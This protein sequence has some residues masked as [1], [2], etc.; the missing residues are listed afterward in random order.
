MDRE[1]TLAKSSKLELLD[2]VRDNLEHITSTVTGP[3]SKLNKSDTNA[4]GACVREVLA[5]V[6][7]LNLRLS[8]AE[9]ELAEAN[10]RVAKAEN[11]A[12]RSELTAKDKAAPGISY[13]TALKLSRGGEPTPMPS[14][15]GPVIAFYPAQEQSDKIRTAEDTKA[16]LKKAIKPVAMEVQVERLRKVGNAGVIVQT[17]TAEGAEKLK[18]AAP[19]TL[20][21]EVP[22]SRSPQVCLRNLDGDLEST[23]ILAA[24]YEKNF[25]GSSWTVARI[26]A[27]CKVFRRRGFRGTTTAVLECSATF[28]QAILEKG[29]VGHVAE[30]RRRR[31]EDFINGHDLLI[32]NEA[33][34]PFTFCGPNG[35]SNIDLTVSTRSCKVHEWQV[36]V[37]MS[38][39][40][41][42]L[43]TFLVGNDTRTVSGNQPICIAPTRFR[44]S[45][46]CWDRFRAG[47]NS[48]MG[49]L[50]ELEERGRRI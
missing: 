12:L 15:N 2:R 43:L 10:L 44:E 40:D 14:G 30:V 6:A 11:R 21:V 24:L 28:R 20:R 19:S 38:S 46:V 17:T 42:R 48:R 16:V 32:R 31:I 36:H 25:K 22:K 9:L 34:Q 13:A 1:R 23:D 27:E 47:I 41:H 3:G 50:N 35:N 49:N 39:S 18:C 26:Q 4:V 33:G 37:E 29:R 8:D 7:A 45:G 5:V